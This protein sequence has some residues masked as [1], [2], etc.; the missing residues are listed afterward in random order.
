M[1]VLIKK[2]LLVKILLKSIYYENLLFTTTKKTY[3][4]QKY[5][6]YLSNWLWM[7]VFCLCKWRIHWRKPCLKI[8]FIYT[9]QNAMNFGGEKE[10]SRYTPKRWTAK[11]TLVGFKLRKKGE[12]LKH[13]IWCANDTFSSPTYRLKMLTIKNAFY[14]FILNFIILLMY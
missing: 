8:F 9:R 14:D 6:K 4:R 7:K 12:P 5:T 3:K 11:T 1:N 13:L 10:P 2:L